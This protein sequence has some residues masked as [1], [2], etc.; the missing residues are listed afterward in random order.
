MIV[1]NRAMMV[2]HSTLVLMLSGAVQQASGF[3]EG[4]CTPIWDTAIGQPGTGRIHDMV[5]FDDGS[6]SGPQL[7]AAVGVGGLRV[8]KWNGTSWISLGSGMNSPVLALAVFNDGTGAALYA[9]GS[10]VLADGVPVNRLAKWTGTTWQSVG[11]GVTGGASVVN[12]MTVHNDGSGSALY[13]AGAFGNAGPVPAGNIAKWNGSSWAALGTGVF[14]NVSSS[15]H[16]LLSVG[17][18]LYVGGEFSHAG[19]FTSPFLVNRIARWNGTS[20]SGLG[21]GMNFGS[22]VESLA[23]FDDGLGGGPLLHAGGTFTMAGDV[24]ANGVA[25]WNG[26]S[27]SPLGAGLTGSPGYARALAV[28]DDGN[29]LALYAGGQFS[30][31]GGTAANRI[32]KWDG[33]QWSP[34]GAGVSSWIETLRVHED[35]T[36]DGPDL[37]VGGEFTMA[38]GM[39]TGKVAV[40]RGCSGGPMPGDINGDGSVNVS[41]MLAVISQWGNC[42]VPCPPACAADVNGNCVVDVA[43]LLLVI[44][45]WG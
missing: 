10:F 27:W 9:G 14:G 23:V 5:V 8:A 38:G 4:P 25:K 6:G 1:I 16:A 32:A 2:V 19:G 39:T 34:L 20:W 12:V 35:N 30:G 43:D 18:T 13:V 41:D 36:G 29:G 7:Y 37:Y 28:F 44:S 26:S 17:S 24:A 42:P 3:G 33:I 45:N 11:G 31:A 21:T 22:M 40:W 15:V